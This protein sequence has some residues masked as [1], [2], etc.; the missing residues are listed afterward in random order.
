MKRR[1]LND[2]FSL[3]ASVSELDERARQG[4]QSQRSKPT[5]QRVQMLGAE[6]EAQDKVRGH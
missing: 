3:E 1:E 6:N 2:L 4:P 5:Q